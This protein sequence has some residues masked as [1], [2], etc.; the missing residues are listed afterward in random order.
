[1]TKE[2]ENLKV[3]QEMF[4]AFGEGKIQEGLNI[5]SKNVDFQS[6]VSRTRPPEISWAKPRH[7]REEVTEYFKELFD[8]VQPERLETIWFTAQDDRVVVE[9][10]NRGMVKSTGKSYEH[11]WVMVFTVRDGEITRFRH[12]YDTADI[13]TAFRGQ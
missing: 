3:V 13:V 10:K 7:S 2:Q 12:Y 11:D 6:P 8:K 5:Y 9:G 4:T 1:M